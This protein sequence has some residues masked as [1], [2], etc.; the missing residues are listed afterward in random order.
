MPFIR[1]KSLEQ[2]FRNLKLAVSEF[3]L[4][5]EADLRIHI[6]QKSELE[7]YLFLLY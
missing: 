3:A 4:E 1:Y 6:L 5:V 7:R 2:L